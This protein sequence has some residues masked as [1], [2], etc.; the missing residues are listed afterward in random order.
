MKKKLKI[1]AISSPGGHFLIELQKICKPLED[2]FNIVYVYPNNQFTK[3]K[4]KSSNNISIIDASAKTN[5][6]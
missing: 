1:I 5:L 3:T 4:D 6:N 2:I